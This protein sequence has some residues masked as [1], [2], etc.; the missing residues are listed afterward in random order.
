M[1]IT[2]SD[3]LLD[4]AYRRGRA[5]VPSDTNEKA[6]QIKFVG[7][8]YRHAIRKNKYWFLTKTYAQSTTDGVNI[9]DLQSDYREMIEVRLD[10][11]LV[12]PEST[13]SATSIYK[14]PPIWSPYDYDGY[15]DWWYYIYDGQII[16]SPTPSETPSA[17]SVSTITVSGTTAT[18][19]TASAH[20]FSDN[21]WVTIAGADQSGLNGTVQVFVSDT[22]TFTY[23]VDSGTA[24][25]TGTITATEAN[26]VSRYFHWPTVSFTSV[27]DTIDLP[28]QY[29]D[30][31]SSFVYAR[32][33]QIRGMRGD[34]ADG[35][36]EH[37]EIIKQMNQENMTRLLA[38]SS[39]PG[40]Y[41]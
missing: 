35:Y 14:T 4:V 21:D 8:A 37:N 40:G 32:L 9:Y 24:N 27:D 31:L 22:T 17:I 20:G 30:V 5:S 16:I 11:T 23:T 36:D 13:R 28:D 18:V 34:A 41:F 19:V 39:N 10:G 6:R 33:A 1:S 26:L 12:A 15:H 2:V 3:I 25:G 7:Q 38:N 29:Q